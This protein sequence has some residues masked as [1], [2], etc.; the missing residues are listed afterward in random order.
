M[1]PVNRLAAIVA[2][3]SVLATQPGLAWFNKTESPNLVGDVI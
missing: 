1:R 2:V 3:S